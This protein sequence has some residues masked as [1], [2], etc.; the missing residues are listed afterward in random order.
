MEE[1]RI[2]PSDESLL[3]SSYGRIMVAPYCTVGGRGKRRLCGGAG[4]FGVWDGSRYIYNRR[5][6]STRKVARLVC[7]AFHGVAPADDSVCK[8]LDENSAN[9]RP[10][11]LRWGTQKQNLNAPGFLAYC[12]GRVGANSATYKG[13]M[14]RA[15]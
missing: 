13:K 5:G 1:W 7:E 3:A 11:N 12:R 8:H 4:T 14:K 6:Y 9:N 15:A 2:V 10:E